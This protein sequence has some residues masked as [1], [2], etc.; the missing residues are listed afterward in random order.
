MTFLSQLNEALQPL[1]SDD[2][3]GRDIERAFD[4]AF[5][6]G[7]RDQWLESQI[8]NTQDGGL[9]H[10]FPLEVFFMGDGLRPSHL[11]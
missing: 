8:L 1:E 3:F 11:L 5:V 10:Y 2:V 9:A 7:K 4:R 6:T